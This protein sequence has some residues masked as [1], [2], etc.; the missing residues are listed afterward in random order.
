MIIIGD[1]QCVLSER[2]F[3]DK[4]SKGIKFELELNSKIN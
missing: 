1:G 2:R 4:N 3:E